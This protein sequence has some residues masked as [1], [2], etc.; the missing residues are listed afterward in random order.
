MNVALNRTCAAGVCEENT[1]A[2]PSNKFVCSTPNL[3]TNIVGFGGFD[4]STI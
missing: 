2:A 1:P 4:S 3:P